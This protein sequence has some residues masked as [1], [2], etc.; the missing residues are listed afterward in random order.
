VNAE[1][2]VFAELE[3]LSERERSRLLRKLIE[4]YGDERAD[5]R[6]RCDGPRR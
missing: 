5:T 3:A 1:D 4:E 2:A 6:W